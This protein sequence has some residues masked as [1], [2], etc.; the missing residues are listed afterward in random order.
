M[1]VV[2]QIMPFISLVGGSAATRFETGE[3]LAR[4]TRGIFRIQRFTLS[5]SLLQLIL[6]GD[7][8]LSGRLN[9]EV[10]AGTSYLG[11]NSRGFQLLGLR[12][13]AI[14]SLPL[15]LI[16]DASA[17]L[18]NRVVHL[19]ITGTYTNPIVRVEPTAL[20]SQESVRFFLS[21]TGLPVTP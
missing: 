10:T 12:L 19:R 4:L 5:S 21:R 16:V 20:L 11:V 13:P 15:A 17:F 1:P 7:V 14:G 18:A 6:E 2:D 9:L 3:I 8:T